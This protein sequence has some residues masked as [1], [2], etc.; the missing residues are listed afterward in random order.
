[1]SSKEKRNLSDNVRSEPSVVKVRNNEARFK[2]DQ[3]PHEKIKLKWSSSFRKLF[4]LATGISSSTSSNSSY[5]EVPNSAATSG[6]IP[7]SE[8]PLLMRSTDHVMKPTRRI[9]SVMFSIPEW[10]PSKVLEVKEAV[11]KRD[12][13][14]PE[15]EREESPP[16]YVFL[17]DADSI[18]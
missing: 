7:S 4:G 2:R 3:E 18:N 10:T 6:S 17:Y 14:I 15:W 5:P 12:E 9:I 16:I 8:P 13:S 1:M 11:L